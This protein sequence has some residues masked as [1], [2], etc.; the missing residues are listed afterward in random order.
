MLV[1]IKKHQ[2]NTPKAYLENGIS[3]INFGRYP[4]TVVTDTTIIANLDTIS[5]TNELGYIEFDGEEYKKVVASP[6]E[7]TYTFINGNTIT[8]GTTYYFK[9]EPIKWRVLYNSDGTYKLLSEMI[10]DNTS[11][12]SSTSSRTINNS[13]IYANNYEYSNIRAWLNGY[14][15]TDYNVSDYTNKGFIDIAFTEV[16]KLLINSTLVDNSLSSTGYTTNPYICNNTTDK[17]Y[18]LSYSDVTNTSYGFSSS[19]SAC[20]VARRAQLSDFA[21]SKG[22]YM[23][24]STSYLGN[25]YWWLRSP[26]NKYSYSA[27]GVFNDG[28]IYNYYVANTDVGARPALEITI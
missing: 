11:F 18:L 6:R 10:L 25:G 27:K 16:E 15:G 22:C 20:D 12:Y 3:Y 9:V 24:T 21:R 19:Y 4:Q 26:S 5:K 13:T 2:A 1:K 23:S 7:S 17:I 14:N 8:S 28:Y